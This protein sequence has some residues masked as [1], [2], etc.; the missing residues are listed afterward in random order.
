M[1]ERIPV[2]FWDDF[3]ED[4]YVPEGEIQ[5]TYAY[6]EDDDIP[7][8]QR[9]GYLEEL[10]KFMLAQLKEELEGIE[11]E[12]FFYDSHE[13]YPDLV[14]TEHEWC[15]FKRW[16]IRLKHITHER[17]NKVVDKLQNINLKY[18]GVPYYIYSES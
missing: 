1:I 7:I 13:K 14:G 16:E 15:L 5:E 12:L 10:M 8:E 4:D 17:L 3:W 2:N 6:V 11:V 18:G 9:K